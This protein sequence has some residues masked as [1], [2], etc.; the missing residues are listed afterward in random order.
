MIKKGRVN[1]I[2]KDGRYNFGKYSEPILR[3]NPLELK[4]GIWGYLP[5]RLKNSRLKESHAYMIG[6]K[7][8][9]IVIGA[10]DLKLFS[11]VRLMV[12]DKE[13]NQTW[14]LSE[15]FPFKNIKVS[16]NLNDDSMFL[17]DGTTKIYANHKLNSNKIEVGFA[18]VDELTGAKLSGFFKVG[19]SMNEPQVSVLPMSNGAGLYT[20]KQLMS[21]EGSMNIGEV[22]H[23]LTQEETCLVL[24]DQKVYYPY[25]TAWDWVTAS[26]IVGDDYCG[27]T[28]SDVKGI[29]NGHNENGFW[30]NGKIMKCLMLDFAG[31]SLLEHG[32]L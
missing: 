10:M 11:V 3:L 17:N 31:I 6:G 14:G 5:P 16:K 29:K 2:D 18:F 27:F 13:N 20:H 8:H 23:V 12:Y 22:T 28:V 9:Y 19:K 15:V 7:N 4:S 21:L 25:N 24:D 1:L 32:Q 30:K 26:G